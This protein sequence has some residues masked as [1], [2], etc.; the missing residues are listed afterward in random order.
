M[1]DQ[2]GAHLVFPTVIHPMGSAGG[3]AKNIHFTSTGG[4][5]TETGMVDRSGT[6]VGSAKY[7]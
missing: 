1:V 2:T 6:V 7:I 3:N 4:C 5:N